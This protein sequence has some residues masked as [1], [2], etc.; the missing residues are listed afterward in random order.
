[1]KQLVIFSKKFSSAWQNINPWNTE[2]PYIPPFG[3]ADFE[4]EYSA[5]AYYYAQSVN[6]SIVSGTPTPTTWLDL[7]GRTVAFSDAAD[8]VAEGFVEGLQIV[9]IHAPPPPASASYVSLSGIVRGVTSNVLTV[10]IT[11]AGP[12]PAPPAFT[13]S[14]QRVFFVQDHNALRHSAIIVQEPEL[15][16]PTSVLNNNSILNP[17]PHRAQVTLLSTNTATVPPPGD[18]SFIPSELWPTVTRAARRFRAGHFYAMR[19]ALDVQSTTQVLYTNRLYFVLTVEDLHIKSFEL[20]T[21]QHNRYQNNAPTPTGLALSGT[22]GGWTLTGTA[23]SV[24]AFV[25]HHNSD[26]V[27][28]QAAASDVT[29]LLQSA[30]NPPLTPWP[31]RPQAIGVAVYYDAAKGG[32]VG[33]LPQ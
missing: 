28:T 32:G 19:T 25:A 13:G 1:M 3:L 14:A 4:L 16:S 11:S 12:T 7:I 9:I 29:E 31:P 10:E 24:T 21:S 30:S 6:I 2:I 22:N 33:C 20:A 18:L 8:W 23:G 26:A 17:H 27:H 15:D 5:Y